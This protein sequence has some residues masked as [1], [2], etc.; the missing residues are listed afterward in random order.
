[1][2]EL[3]SDVEAHWPPLAPLEFVKSKVEMAS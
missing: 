2:N 1:M 3:I